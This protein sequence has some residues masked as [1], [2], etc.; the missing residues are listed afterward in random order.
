MSTRAKFSCPAILAA[1]MLSACGEEPREAPVEV[2]AQDPLLARAL[3]DP[4]MVDPDLS[5][6]SEANAALAFRDGHP[7]PL[8]SAHEDASER[9][10]DAARIELL[11]GGAIPTLPSASGFS[12]AAALGE[13]TGAAEI[14]AALDARTDC[15]EGLSSSL[16]WSLRLP[17]VVEVMP[18]GMVQQAAGVDRGECS[19]RVVRYLTPANAEDVLE[20]YFA[21]ADRERFRIER[22]SAPEAQIA[23]ERRDQAMAVHVREGAAGMTEVDLVYWRK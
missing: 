6:R 22:F 3:N 21:K 19:V 23:A 1:L 13:L 7:L 15:A 10:R 9:A 11:E 4:L 17:A 14:L 16:D 20:Y 8:F 12:G 2:L 5:W 18:H